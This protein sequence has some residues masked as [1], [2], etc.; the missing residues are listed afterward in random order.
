MFRDSVGNT[1]TK[2]PS[3]KPNRGAKSTSNK[4]DKRASRRKVRDTNYKHFKNDKYAAY[5]LRVGKPLGPG[6]SGNKSGKNKRTK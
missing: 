3:R 1:Y 2:L 4:I 5:R 6:I